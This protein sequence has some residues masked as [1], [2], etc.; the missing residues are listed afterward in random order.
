MPDIDPLSRLGITHTSTGAELR[1][2]SE[3][4]SD[5]RLC[6]F[7]P[8]DP[9]KIRET[10]S[11]V[12]EGPSIWRGRSDFLVPETP[13]AVYV[14][15]PE[16]P[17]NAF[18]ESLPL[19]DPYARGLVQI[20]SERW[21]GT[22]VDEQFDW[23]SSHKP[24]TSLDRTVIYEAHV[25]GLTSLNPEV[26]E[27]LR[28]TYAG[29]GHEVIINYLTDLGVTALELLPV[30]AFASERRLRE[31]GLTNYWGYNTL[32]FFSPHC[33]YATV[34]S[35]RI[36]PSAILHEFK[37]MVKRL[38]EAGIEVILD[39][40]YNH[41]AEEGRN[42]PTLSLRGIDNATYYRQDEDG[43]YIDVTGCGNTV[44]FGHPT[45]SR[46]VLDSLRY[47]TNEVQIDGFRFD[48]ATVLGRDETGAYTPKH[49]LLAEILADPAL[50]SAKMIAEP[51]DVGIGGWQTG[52]FP[53]GF[54]EWNDRYRDR[55]R[56]FWLADIEHARNT[57]Q[58][59]VGIGG[60]ATRLA[61]SSNTFSEERGPLASINFVTAHDGFTMADLTAFN[62]KHNLANGENNADGT[63]NNRSFN[64]G[65][66]GN[67]ADETILRVRRKAHRNLMGTLLL[68]AGVPMITAGD[69]Y[70]R[71]QYG[72]NNP[73]CE[74][75]PLAWLS[76]LRTHKQDELC[77]TTRRLIQL[78]QE[79]PALRP[80]RYAVLGQTTPNASHMDWYD[81]SGNL[82]NDEDWNSPRNR[83]LQYLATS[84][85]DKENLNCVL[86][87]VHGVEIDIDVTLPIGNGVVSYQLLWD[88]AS[89]SPMNREGEVV[90][91]GDLQ[92]VSGTS[93]QLY[94]AN[95]K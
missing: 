93:L 34:Q 14:S 74:D 89:D 27:E 19:V 85:P 22:V 41:T 73:Y 47:W 28:G 72:N 21:L 61:G 15:G 56:N 33:N 49:P 88:S 39:V 65:T 20:D 82:M 40:V 30:H 38:H 9:S 64:H 62:N 48:L 11:M 79:N 76:W 71:T 55:V 1:I 67:T 80:S 66:E 4:A 12:K 50:Q 24:A 31:S 52:N 35:R 36:G 57:G 51:W 87:I 26:P 86:L 5:M 17:K 10:I 84:T 54:S 32:N 58:A 44:N 59:P 91:P 37:T 42:G 23:G 7:D 29:I 25:H 78:R 83:T 18:D 6:V 16:E 81:A 90:L 94:R 68:S 3:N 8:A 63:D 53:L 70:G 95:C 92:R 60:F 45:P 69:E 77:A 13:Y 43:N 75:N 2:F 46:L